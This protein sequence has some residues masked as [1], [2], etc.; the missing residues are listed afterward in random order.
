MKRY[1]KYRIKEN[2]NDKKI[3]ALAVKC[4]MCETWSRFDDA[5][6]K[7]FTNKITYLDDTNLCRFVCPKCGNIFD[8][9]Y[10]SIN[11]KGHPKYTDAPYSFIGC[12]TEEDV[13]KDCYN[14]I[15]GKLDF[16]LNKNIKISIDLFNNII[17]EGK[18]LSKYFHAGDHDVSYIYQYGFDIY[19]IKIKD[20]GKTVTTCILAGRTLSVADFGKMVMHNGKLKKTY[21]DEKN[22]T[23]IH[24]YTY[25]NKIYWIRV[26]NNGIVNACD[27]VGEALSD[28]K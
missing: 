11:C 23:K 6:I 16:V 24:L 22:H 14:V 26:D 5:I 3:Q 21:T 1:I 27:I 17:N 4:P 12:S 19:Y 18:Q 9:T 28:D 20:D 8:N 13:Y 7:G 2:K 25:N 15:D 10:V